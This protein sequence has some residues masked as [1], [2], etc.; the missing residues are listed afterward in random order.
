MDIN[1]SEIADKIFT[2]LVGSNFKVEAFNNKGGPE[3]NPENA[4]RFVSPQL[5]V[6]LDRDRQSIW[7]DIQEESAKN[8][9]INLLKGIAK[10][11][12]LDFDYKVFGRAIKP[13][14]EAVLGGKKPYFKVSPTVPWTPHTNRSSGRKTRPKKTRQE[15]IRVALSIIDKKP[16][17]HV[18]KIKNADQA[19][20]DREFNVISSH[21]QREDA[22]RKAKLYALSNDLPVLEGVINLPSKPKRDTIMTAIESVKPRKLD[23]VLPALAAGVAG[24]M[25]AG[26]AVR[27]GAGELGSALT[28]SAASSAV[29]SALSS[30][31]LE[32]V[33]VDEAHDEDHND[34]IYAQMHAIAQNIG[35]RE[36][37]AAE[38]RRKIFHPEEF[39]DQVKFSVNSEKA[40]HAVTSR[41]GDFISQDEHGHLVAPRKIWSKIEQ[42]AYDA[43][44][45]GA[46]EI[47]DT[48]AMQSMRTES[49]DPSGIFHAAK[50][51]N[52]S[53]LVKAEMSQGGTKTFRVKAQSERVAREKFSQQHAQAKVLSVKEESVS[54]GSETQKTFK[55][56]YHSPKT[57]RNVTK[58]VKANNESDIWDKLQ[59]KGINIISVSQQGMAE[60]SEEKTPE[61]YKKLAQKH[62]ADGQTGT[63]ANR[64]YAHK[65]AGRARKAAAILKQGGSQAEAWSHYQGTDKNGMAEGQQVNEESHD[66]YKDYRAMGHS[67]AEAMKAAREYEDKQKSRDYQDYVTKIYIND[68]YWQK[69]D[70][71]ILGERG[72]QKAAQHAANIARKT[73]KRVS[74][75]MLDIVSGDTLAIAD[76]DNGKWKYRDLTASATESVTEDSTDRT[77]HISKNDWVPFVDWMES[78][79]LGISEEDG[80]THN[81]LGDVIEL[82]FP[83]ANTSWNNDAAWMYAS[84]W[85]VRDQNMQEDAQI[86]EAF[87]DDL[88]KLFGIIG[89]AGTIGYGAWLDHLATYD[90]PLVHE[91][92]RQAQA[93]NEGAIKDLHNISLRDGSTVEMNRL[94]NKYGFRSE[95]ERKSPEP[96]MERST[97][98]PPPKVGFAKH[99]RKAKARMQRHGAHQDR[100]GVPAPYDEKKAKTRKDIEDYFYKKEIG[101]TMKKQDVAE[102]FWQDAVKKA[103]AEREARKGK[104]FEKNP[105]SH[106]KQGVYKGDKDLAGN[107]VPKRKK[108]GVAEGY[109]ESMRAAYD[110]GQEAGKKSWPANNNPYDPKTQPEH[111]KEWS[112]GHRGVVPDRSR[113]MKK[114]GMAEASKK[115]PASDKPV[116]PK[117]V[118]VSLKDVPVKKPR[119]H[120]QYDPAK[121][122]PG[123]KVFQKEGMAESKI[124]E[125]FGHMLGSTK[126]SYQPLDGVKIIVRHKSAVSE[127]VRGSR[128][129]NIKEIF[130]QRG[131]ERFKM[132]EASLQAARAMA[133][134]VHSGGE[135]YDQV[136]KAINEM[137]TEQ[138]ALANFVRF[139]SR[140]GMVNETNQEYVDLATKRVQSIRETFRKLMG[141]KTYA[142]A[143]EHINNEVA[144]E[145]T[146]TDLDLESKFTSISCDKRVTNAVA[147]M[148]A[149]LAR[150]SA[151]EGAIQEAINKEDFGAIKSRL[152]E[153]DA[154]QFENGSARLAY[155]VSQLSTVA[156]DSRLGNYL[157]NISKKIGEGIELEAFETKT[158]KLCLERA[159]CQ[160]GRKKSKMESRDAIKESKSY[161]EFIEKFDIF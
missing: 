101:E 46:E 159:K 148:Q 32:D 48:E 23:E 17:Y 123:V 91:I 13:K 66:V 34:K 79:G 147:S 25:A 150:Q 81:D 149:A 143:V 78:E 18:I 84:E 64:D 154:I 67:H 87:K 134:H 139:V 142:N 7:V 28:G 41:W 58:I 160:G 10:E 124:L 52:K 106:D 104:P 24:R 138:K 8:S 9:V 121:D 50:N 152:Q 135:V 115:I 155:Q 73:G 71:N 6:N 80:I 116:K 128:S 144:V 55:V 40:Q 69:G 107:P 16:I 145:L 102:G 110:K 54:E 109:D 114:Q 51:L 103:E 117:D 43:D 15:G 112:A 95:Y 39:A 105:A 29:K 157:S 63:E 122:F 118:L 153:Q 76:F 151:F 37:V 88:K 77:V 156:Q 97:P 11:H 59:L 70:N 36:V 4:S 47:Y 61:Y 130:I 44:G 3:L 119:G 129:R 93:G 33:D 99:G 127:E 140:S 72:A 68:K 2:T 120:K 45:E 53:F 98:V 14:T 42:V 26:A 133:R 27:A 21:D 85:D 82:V 38:R 108:Q 137:A 146:E 30:K 20:Q 126:T 62:E 19:N 94:L 100:F 158:V 125:G 22:E 56:V 92:V 12:G 83:P 35:D 89:L 113:F 86:D 136:G 49:S 60:G 1:Y 31:D 75:H 132:K 74:I 131:D 5:T 90:T 161:V 65:M 57:D 111:H 96:T 141:P